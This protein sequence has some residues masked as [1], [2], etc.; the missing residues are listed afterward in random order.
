[1]KPSVD[2]SLLKMRDMIMNPAKYGIT[3]E[4]A[5]QWLIDNVNEAAETLEEVPECLRDE[6]SD[7]IIAVYME[8]RRRGRQDNKV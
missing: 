3:R 2:E 7:D 8:K 6:L 4:Q 1:M 5:V